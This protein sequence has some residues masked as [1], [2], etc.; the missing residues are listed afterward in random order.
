MPI[1]AA[2]EAYFLPRD[3]RGSNQRFAIHHRPSAGPIRGA[4]VYVH[5]FA[6]E[7]NKSRRMAALQSRAFAHAGFSVLQIDLLGCGDSSGDHGDATW[8]VWVD[9]I[10][11][12]S[13]WLLKRQ[14]APL[15]LWGLRAG[16]LLAVEAAHRLDVPL[17]L[18][19]WQPTTV[20]T[21]V[22]QQFLR[23][24]LAA[25]LQSTSGKGVLDALRAQL[26]AGNAVH[27]A[28]YRVA[29]SMA[30]A[31]ERATL[32]PPRHA[33]K[34]TWLEVSGRTAAELLPASASAVDRWRNAGC[35]VDTRVVQGPPF[36]HSVEIEEAPALIDA[37][38][39]AM[40]A[41]AS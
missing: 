25:K 29:A 32:K 34:V 18:L 13:R 11:E 15:T 22:L 8:D 21:T 14:E 23:L 17:D 10:V 7:M 28:G 30:A 24:E 2:R 20:G 16:C 5:P 33:G 19:F 36:W 41:V 37:T 12:A 39:A 38:L 27:V 40:T 35:E 4:L 9:D 1:D 31:I 6:E 3:A 26:A